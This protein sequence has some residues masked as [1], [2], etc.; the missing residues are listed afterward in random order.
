MNGTSEWLQE[1]VKLKFW[2]TNLVADSQSLCES[3]L[4]RA[5][6]RIIELIEFV[7]G[8]NLLLFTDF[9]RWVYRKELRPS[10]WQLCFFNYYNE[11]PD[12]F[13]KLNIMD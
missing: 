10:G 3:E 7:W 13:E 2:D 5:I 1:E 12:F 8:L 11:E 9:L 4:P 6:R